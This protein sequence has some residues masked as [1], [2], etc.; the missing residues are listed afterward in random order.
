M[1]RFVMK[2]ASKVARSLAVEFDRIANWKW[3][4]YPFGSTPRANSEIYQRLASEV[5]QKQYPEIDKFEQEQ[6][7]AIDTEW[8]HNL[9]LHTQVVVKEAEIGYQHGRLLY[10]SIRS[11][12][13]RC[14]PQFM[15]ILEAGTARGF[16][17][18]CM[19][20]AMADAGIE[21]KLLTFDVLPHQTKM[22]WNCIDDT[23]GPRTR[24]ELIS[25][26]SELIDRYLI[27]HQGDTRI[28][29][30]KVQISRIHFAFLD[31]V[32]TYEYVLHE[33]ECIRDKQRAGDVICFDDY[34]TSQ[35]PGVVKA[36]DE[37]CH[38]Y[39]YSRSVVPAYENRIYVVAT[40]LRD[41]IARPI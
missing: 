36:V 12:I 25:N 7:F 31:G 40:K 32:H 6:G 4:N 2:L 1:P 3:Y 38:R 8:F 27:F 19:A 21:G 5:R 34:S 26:Y 13:Q 39:K 33:V 16:S 41:A 24:E 18:L 23:E 17:A 22:Y 30:P 28:E 14:Q 35:F 29:L 9:A 15:N 10:A 11:Y 37:I 20:K